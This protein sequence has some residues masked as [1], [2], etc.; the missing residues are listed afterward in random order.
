VEVPFTPTKS[1][2]LKHGC[3]MGKMVGGVLSVE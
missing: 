3:A 1:G 2:E